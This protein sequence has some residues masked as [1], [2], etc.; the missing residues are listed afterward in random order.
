MSSEPALFSPQVAEA[1]EVWSRGVEAAAPL[2]I[3]AL[4]RRR[5]A[6]TSWCVPVHHGSEELGISLGGGALM[7]CPANGTIWSRGG[8]RDPIDG[9][10]EFARHEPA[11][12]ALISQP[13]FAAT[14]GDGLSLTFASHYM[15]VDRLA[16]RAEAPFALRLHHHCPDRTPP[17]PIEAPSPV[18][19]TATASPGSSAAWDAARSPVSWRPARPSIEGRPRP[20]ACQLEGFVALPSLCSHP[21]LG[22]ARPRRLRKLLE[23]AWTRTGWSGMPRRA[24]SLWWL[25]GASARST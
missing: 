18:Q 9:E 6:R 21:A 25:G 19:L 20:L 8:R 16:C 15:S 4:I 22:D 13:T 7:L 24:A 2:P 17:Y 11:M 5:S 14:P 1:V 12:D 3:A 23:G 10:S